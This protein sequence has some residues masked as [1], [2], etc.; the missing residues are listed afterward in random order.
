M[1]SDKRV[2][3]QNLADG[4]PFILPS[5]K[6]EFKLMY[7][8]RAGDS[9]CKVQGYRI[10]DAGGYS[11]Y[12]DFF[13]PATEVLHDHTRKILSINKEGALSI[14]KEHLNEIFADKQEEDKEQVSKKQKTKSKVVKKMSIENI[15]NNDKN[16]VG[17]PKKHSIQLP[18][19]EEFTV[20]KIAQKL[21]VKKFVVNNE[22]TRIKRET[23][24][25][26]KIVGVAQKG[27]GKPAKVFKII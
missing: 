12:S 2:R 3:L 9:T 17:R 27:K 19:G 20:S 13:A 10:T 23:P 26:I 8:V 16:A 5:L 18:H 7:L 6:N 4:S 25:I 24:E 14:P 1:T 11:P 22:I 21:G 15:E